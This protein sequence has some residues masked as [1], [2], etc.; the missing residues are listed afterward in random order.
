M[1]KRVR[2]KKVGHSKRSSKTVVRTKHRLSPTRRAI[3]EL[4]T[5]SKQYSGTELAKQAHALELALASPETTQAATH[6]RVM[7]LA[8]AAE[9]KGSV[10]GSARPRTK[11]R[12]ASAAKTAKRTTKAKPS[13]KTPIFKCRGDYEMCLQRGG[14]FKTCAAWAAVC[15]SNQL[16]LGWIATGYG[17]FKIFL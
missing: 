17:A 1:A 13:Y 4:R 3:S 16:K 8:K 7:A 10:R 6:R 12:T 14:G 5:V 9:A 15:I 11:T 2:R